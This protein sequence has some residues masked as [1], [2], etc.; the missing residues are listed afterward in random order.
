MGIQKETGSRCGSSKLSPM[1]MAGHVW[2]VGVHIPFAEGGGPFQ[3]VLARCCWWVRRGFWT[4]RESPVER[5]QG[6]GREKAGAQRGTRA[7]ARTG[8]I[9]GKL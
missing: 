5:A 3:L 4:V 1:P 8:G 2:C 6:K 9:E 7:D